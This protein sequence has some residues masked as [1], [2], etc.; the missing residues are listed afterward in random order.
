MPNTAHPQR[1]I[2]SVALT[3]PHQI[4]D[5]ILL[6]LSKSCAA[7]RAHCQT[8]VYM[9][10]ANIRQ[11]RF[12]PNWFLASYTAVSLIFPEQQTSPSAMLCIDPA[13]P[14][15]P[16]SSRPCKD[17]GLDFFVLPPKRPTQRHRRDRI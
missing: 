17:K 14:S 3:P 11:V 9:K 16:S 13:P 8:Q 15:R 2:R 5:L 12:D 7:G 4:D 6:R 10:F 1:S